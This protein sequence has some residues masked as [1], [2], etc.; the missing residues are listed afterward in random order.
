MARKPKTDAIKAI[1]DAVAAD[2]AKKP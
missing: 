2:E 1:K